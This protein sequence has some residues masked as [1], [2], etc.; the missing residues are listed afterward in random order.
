[1]K[2]KSKYVAGQLVHFRNRK[3]VNIG[4]LVTV[5]VTP[6]IVFIVTETRENIF[7]PD[8]TVYT[9]VNERIGTIAV[10]ECEIAPLS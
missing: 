1:M 3:F 5:D 6:N 10:D 7:H 4:K 8:L 9:I 2:N